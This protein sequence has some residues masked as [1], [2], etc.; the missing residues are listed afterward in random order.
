MEYRARVKRRTKNKKKKVKSYNLT[1]IAPDVNLA[2]KALRRHGLSVVW[3]E[4]NN[5]EK[6]FPREE[7]RNWWEL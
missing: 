2:E 4:R 3:I 5:P 1:L 7:T 6:V